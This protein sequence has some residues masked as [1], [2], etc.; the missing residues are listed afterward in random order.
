M[1]SAKNRSRSL[2]TK[3]RKPDSVS[4]QGSS[5]SEDGKLS[6]AGA[7]TSLIFVATNTWQQI[8]VFVK[9]YY[10]LQKHNFLAS[11]VLSRQAYFCLDKR[12]V[13]VFVATKMI[14][15]AAPANDSNSTSDNQKKRANKQPVTFLPLRFVIILITADKRVWR[16]SD[17]V[18]GP[19]EVEKADPSDRDTMSLLMT[20]NKE[21]NKKLDCLNETVGRLQGEV[22]DLKQENSKLSQC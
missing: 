9:F 15:V 6:M 1:S 14:L 4:N 13:L 11:K 16:S 22:F 18:S 21:L 12:R 20:V 7:A 10:K 5:S 19:C 8:F 2:W 17:S 3:R